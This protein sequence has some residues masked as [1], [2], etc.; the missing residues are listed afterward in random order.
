LQRLLSDAANRDRSLSD[1]QQEARAAGRELTDRLVTA[2][3][4]ERLANVEQPADTSLTCDPPTLMT[5]WA[6][7][8]PMSLRFEEGNV[9]LHAQHWNV[10]RTIRLSGAAA[11]AVGE[12]S[13]YGNATARFEGATLVIESVNVFPMVTGEA[14]T[15]NKARITER[16]TPS[17]DGLRLDSELEI[18]DPETYR[19]PRSWYRP[20][21]R[22]PEVQIVE[23]DPCA[24]IEE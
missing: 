9:I 10:V 16:Y 23:D 4:R 2:A 24:N 14:I 1:L 7:P 21:V 15:S 11:V 8:L 20:R 13:L 22:T 6:N 3:G 5:V 18:D 12:P 19:E 17:E